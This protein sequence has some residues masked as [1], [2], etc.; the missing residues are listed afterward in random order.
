MPPAPNHPDFGPSTLQ[1]DAALAHDALPAGT[2]LGGYQIVEVLGRASFGIVYLALDSSL[3]RQVAIKEYLP[4]DLATRGEG[5]R[6]QRHP[7]ADAAAFAHGL[8]T[9][10][11]EARLLARFDHASLAHVHSYWEENDSAY[12]V[13]PY[14]VG[15]SLTAALKTLG[16]P[17]DEGW[18]RAM[19]VPLSSA[20]NTLHVAHCTHCNI[21]PDSIFVLADGNPLLTGF[22]EATRL[23]GEPAPAQL[24]VLNPAFAPFEQ[25]THS[26]TLPVGPWTDLYALAAVLHFILS[27]RPPQPATARATSDQLRPLA[28]TLRGLAARFPDLH[29]TP[30]FLAGIDQAL[31]LRPKDR[32]RNVA[33]FMQSLDKTP[34][35]AKPAPLT[36]APPAV[37]NTPRSSA[38]WFSAD[39]TI[40][41]P[42]PAPRRWLLW[43][44]ATLGVAAL[45]AGIAWWMSS[46]P[47]PLSPHLVTAAAPRTLASA[48]T[49]APT[50]PPTLEAA[51]A[52]ASIA[53]PASAPIVIAAAPPASALPVAEPASAP[54]PKI[55]PEN[56]PEAEAERPQRKAR[57]TEPDNPRAAC[58][59][60]ANF[61]LVYCMQTQCKKPKFAQHPQCLDLKRRGEVN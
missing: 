14:Y 8:H 52:A 5:F 44:G 59:K 21:S 28:E 54:A 20:L 25:Y 32:P 56:K 36:A 37:A 9:F 24:Q 50:S 29:Y 22:G 47:Q 30:S 39:S 1:F 11:S 41:P 48:A 49:A 23:A 18:L 53:L 45:A 2:R 6:V 27:G 46:S 4:A 3:Q 38:D 34:P 26:A 15:Q 55:E 43:V 60:R 31:S 61:S 58:G 42:P 7:G 13:T 40:D 16:H 33:E 57:A 19:L 17:P 35:P 12:M 51:S 10:L